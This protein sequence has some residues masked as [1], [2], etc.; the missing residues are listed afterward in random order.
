MAILRF[1]ILLLTFCSAV[2]QLQPARSFP[3]GGGFRKSLQQDVNPHREIDFISDTQQPMTVEKIKLHSNHNR[4]ATS[5]LLSDM[6]RQKPLAIYMLGDIV[7][8][9]SSRHKWSAMDRFIDTCRKNNIVVHGLLGNHDL[10][11]NRKKGESNFRQRFPGDSALGY[12]SITD[13]VAVVMLNS[14]FGKLSAG[15]IDQQER[16]YTTTL[17]L[18]DSN[19]A[20][21]TI[22]VSCHHSPYSN[23]RIVG[24]SVPVQRYFLPAFM[25]TAKCRLFISG[26]AHAFEHFVYGGKSFLVIGGGGGLH[27]PL[28]T[29]AGRLSDI[30]F[31]YKPMFHYLSLERNGD[32]LKI[33]SRFLQPDFSG[34][35]DGYS[36]ELPL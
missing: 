30:A 13:S 3:E 5:L 32:K 6:L 2:A 16:W 33:T 7:A 10:M 22:I 36:F 19:S 9:G 24:S 20:I 18:L 34:I 25:Q 15:E 28:D 31:H 23:S 27:Q 17:Q 29:S 1:R 26:H 14:N 35:Q 11:W 12:V 4:Q 21:S 8:V